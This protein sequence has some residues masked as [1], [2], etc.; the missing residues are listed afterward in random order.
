MGSKMKH[1][2]YAAV[3]V[4]AIG[5]ATGAFACGTHQHTASTDNGKVVV[6]Q[7]QGAPAME[8]PAENQDN[9]AM[10]DEDKSKE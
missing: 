2:I 10:T 6:A 8:N 3:T 4:S 1:L 7:Q 5:L 9:S